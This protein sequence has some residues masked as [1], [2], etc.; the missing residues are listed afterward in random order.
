MAGSLCFFDLHSD[1]VGY[2]PEK[3]FG[4]AVDHEIIQFLQDIAS[5]KVS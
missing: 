4:S 2:R 5:R 3:S 1:G